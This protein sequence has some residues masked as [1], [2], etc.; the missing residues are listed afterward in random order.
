LCNDIIT[1]EN[2]SE[3][4]IIPNA[5]GGK[6]KVTGF[7][8][9][10]CNVKSG[11]SW[12]AE[13]ARQL[14]PLSLF[15]GITR[16]RGFVPS[17]LIE[18]SDGEQ[19]IYHSDGRMTIAKPIYNEIPYGDG[20]K[21]SF[22]A[23]SIGEARKM[24]KGVK[25]KYPQINLEEA[26]KHLVA[27]SNYSDDMLKLELSLGGQ[28]AGRSIVKSA[29]AF[30]VNSGVDP[31]SCDEAIRYLRARDSEPCFGY[32]YESDLLV[33]RPHGVVFHCVAVMGNEDTRQLL[34]Y[35][36]YFG[37]WR[38][39]ICLTNTYIGPSFS[40]VYAVDPIFGKE[41]DIDIFNSLNKEKAEKCCRCEKISYKDIV[42]AFNKVIPIGIKRS[43]EDA[44]G[45]AIDEALQYAFKNCGGEE[46]QIMTALQKQKLIELF[47]EK[48]SPF[49][50]HLVKKI[51]T[52]NP[53]NNDGL[54]K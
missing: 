27:E 26:F 45:R 37:M 5:I 50:E 39:L 22:S 46:G 10:N 1:K 36:E 8:C 19:I 24:L 9:S 21:V 4:H 29:L 2:D 47:M 44:Q 38:M 16:E 25:R 20:T 28:K 23:R 18:R 12:D 43:W 33:A 31:K 14:N 15:F 7:I 30:A 52:Q 13:L 34:G 41:I 17:Q 48:M 3:E 40:S 11:E 6:R 51:S 54:E 35:V 42:K 32:Y 49:I 53:L